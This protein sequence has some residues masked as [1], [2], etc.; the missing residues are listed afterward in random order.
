ME[1]E[2]KERIHFT[3][4]TS[5]CIPPRH[6]ATSSVRRFLNAGKEKKICDVARRPCTASVTGFG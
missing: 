6:R 4:Y 1:R 2:G 3:A 5:R